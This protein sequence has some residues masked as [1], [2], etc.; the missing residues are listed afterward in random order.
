MQ[1]GE[2]RGNQLMSKTGHVEIASRLVTVARSCFLAH[3][4]LKHRVI[5]AEAEKVALKGEIGIVAEDIGRLDKC[6]TNLLREKREM[7][8][9]ISVSPPHDKQKGNRSGPPCSY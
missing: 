2:G 9:A 3:A 6:A 8:S 1:R 5:S 4:G 7:W